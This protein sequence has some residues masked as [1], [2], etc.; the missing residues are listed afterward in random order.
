M[1]NPEVMKTLIMTLMMTTV[2][3]IDVPVAETY[4]E[5]VEMRMK[6]VARL[7]RS[8]LTSMLANDQSV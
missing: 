4:A 3:T 6:F 8:R 7:M 1:R 5:V 2:A